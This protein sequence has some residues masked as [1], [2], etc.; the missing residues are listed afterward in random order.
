MLVV[1]K[2]IMKDEAKYYVDIGGRTAGPF[3]LEKMERPLNDGT[4]SDATIY[5]T[6]Q[7]AEWL[8]VKT[9]RPFLV[10]LAAGRRSP[11]MSAKPSAK[12]SDWVCTTCGFVGSPKAE[13][14]GSFLVELALWILF[15]F[16]GVIYSV[17]RL[18]G[19]KRICPSCEGYAIIP[20]KSVRG[21]QIVELV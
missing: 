15:C 7:A 13:V 19:R 18:T 12:R 5:C 2:D 21:R 1:G 10:A 3:S 4:I 6:E 14:K 8:P 9:L 16:P 17:W 20:A 11:A